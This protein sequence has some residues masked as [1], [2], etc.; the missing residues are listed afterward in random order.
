MNKNKNN[1]KFSFFVNNTVSSTIVKLRNT[2][3]IK[4]ILNFDVF[5]Y[6]NF[7]TEKLQIIYANIR[8]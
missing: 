7:Y 5:H 6:S 8:V 1:Q 3:A 4:G 2:F